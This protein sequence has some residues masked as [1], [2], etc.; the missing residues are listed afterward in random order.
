MKPIVETSSRIEIGAIKTITKKEV[1]AKEALRE[2]FETKKPK[3]KTLLEA[4]DIIVQNFILRS[5]RERGYFDLAQIIPLEQVCSNCNG[6]GNKFK[7][8]KDRPKTGCKAC[9]GTGVRKN[10][11]KCLTCGGTGVF[12]KNRLEAV[13]KSKNE[14]LA[15]KGKGLPPDPPQNPVLTPDLAELVKIK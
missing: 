2:F 5:L 11:S 1:S 3:T 8:F 9:N 13:I 15:C 7:F 12:E 10:R 14:C 4:R 6:T